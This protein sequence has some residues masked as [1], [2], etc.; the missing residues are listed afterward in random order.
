MFRE[1]RRN[2]QQLSPEICE[3]ILTRGTSGVLALLGDDDYPYAVP[4]SYV[5][6][7]AKLYFHCA[8]SGHKLD[9]I[10][11]SSKAS[12]CVI[13]QDEIVPEEYTSYFRSVIAFGK[14]RIL[15]DDREKREA[16][17]KLAA[18]YAPDDTVSNRQEAIEHSWA[19][20][21]MLEMTIEHMTGKEAIE[22]L[23]RRTGTN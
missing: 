18:K 15:E 17:E 7:G 1:M 11:K 12:F 9:A 10:R 14:I 13:D 16:V 3:D 22:L 8:K 21:C 5:Y 4:I 19:P 20:L 2:K 6:D 23:R